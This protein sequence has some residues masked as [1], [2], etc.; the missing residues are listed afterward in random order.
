MN[1]RQAAHD[2]LTRRET[3]GRLG[4][5]GLGLSALGGGLDALL[6]SEAIAAPARGSLR[7]IEHVI[8]LIQ[9]NRSFDHYFGTLSGVRGFGD[10]HCGPGG[11]STACRTSPTTGV[12]STRPTTTGG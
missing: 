7:D 6:A 9:E 5:A 1:E 10:R 2:G 4:A 12:P 11:S 3:L 8:F